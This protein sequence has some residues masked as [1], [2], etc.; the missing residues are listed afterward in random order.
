MRVTFQALAP[1]VKI[2]NARFDG[3]AFPDTNGIQVRFTAR[4]DG[5]AH[6]VAAWGGHPFIYEVDLF[7]ETNGSGD[8]TLAGQGPS[9]NVDQSVPVAPGVWRLVLQNA[10]VGFGTTGLTA[11]VSWP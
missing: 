6:L 8:L 11:T 5:D 4:S 7:D 10:E 1:S 9:T 2:A 3:T